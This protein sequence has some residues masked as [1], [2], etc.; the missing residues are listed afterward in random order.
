M[1]LSVVCGAV[2]WHVAVIKRWG[3]YPALS[4]QASDAIICILIRSPRDF[5]CIEERTT[6]K[7]HG[8]MGRCWPWRLKGWWPQSQITG[9]TSA[10]RRGADT[11]QAPGGMCLQNTSQPSE[12]DGS[13][14]A[15]E[16]VREY[17]A[18]VLSHWATEFMVT[19]YHGPG[20]WC[21]FLLLIE[22]G[23]KYL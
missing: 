18:V 16:T 1:L 22:L 12:S 6:W 19:F 14:L 13:L 3:D 23:P 17:F 4:R 20:V 5:T 15:F 9:S 11:P 10:E 2:G 7:L 8:E 21:S